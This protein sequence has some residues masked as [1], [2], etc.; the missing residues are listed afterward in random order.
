MPGSK[1]LWMTL[2]LADQPAAEVFE[3]RHVDLDWLSEESSAGAG[4]K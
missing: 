4:A 1:H 3:L 2:D